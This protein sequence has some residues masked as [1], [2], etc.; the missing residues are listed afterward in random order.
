MNADPVEDFLDALRPWL[1][2]HQA[3]FDAAIVT[4]IQINAAFEQ[5]QRRCGWQIEVAPKTSAKVLEA[6]SVDEGRVRAKV[7]A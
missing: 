6:W 7:G 3:A 5:K 1:R 2:L 4:S